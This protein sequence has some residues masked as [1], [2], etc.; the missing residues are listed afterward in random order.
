[1]PYTVYLILFGFGIYKFLIYIYI[2]TRRM[3]YTYIHDI[4]NYALIADRSLSI[5]THT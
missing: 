3:K 2:S 4:V 5:L 1:M